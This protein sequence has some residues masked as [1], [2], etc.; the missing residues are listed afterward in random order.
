MGVCHAATVTSSF[1]F[2]GQ[3]FGGQDVSVNIPISSTVRPGSSATLDLFIRGD[4]DT[5]NELVTVSI[6]GTTVGQAGT[7]MSGAFLGT[8]V[9]S[10]GPGDI[11]FMRTLVIDLA[12]LI[13]AFNGD[14]VATLLFDRSSNVGG[15]ANSQISGTLT[16]AAVPE[17]STMMLTGLGLVCAGCYTL[18][19]RRQTLP[20]STV[21]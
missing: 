8:N 15:G 18:R 17:P 5:M 4:Y 12:D 9:T 21:A 14:S 10:N 11:S 1:N 2:V 16:F 6:D 3:S 19:R 20:S 7:P 13:A